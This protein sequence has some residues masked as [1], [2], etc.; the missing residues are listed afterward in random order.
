MTL[1]RLD[2]RG[3]PGPYVEVLPRPLDERVIAA[4][5]GVPVRVTQEI[6]P[7]AMSRA[8]DGTLLIDFGQNLTGWLRIRASGPDGTTIRV[9]HGLWRRRWPCSRIWVT[10]AAR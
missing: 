6:A 4:D 1:T 7:A 2:L 9:R 3:H 5:P 10:R 8:A